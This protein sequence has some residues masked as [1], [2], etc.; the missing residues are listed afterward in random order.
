M[1]NPTISQIKVGNTTYDINDADA[2]KAVSKLNSWILDLQNSLS[3]VAASGG[4]TGVKGAG[5]PNY[6]QG[7]VNLT[8]R[9]I[10]PS[11]T[12]LYRTKMTDFGTQQF[13]S[14]ASAKNYTPSS[15]SGYTPVMIVG[16]EF[17][18]GGNLGM[19]V[20]AMRCYDGKVYLD[21]RNMNS[22]TLNLGLKVRC[23][24]VWSTFFYQE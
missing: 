21:V 6:R 14:G 3:E 2:R 11:T 23:L 15:I 20:E 22:S 12:Y 8:L 24:Y 13:A 10:I 5:E 4:V 1:A 7:N 16:V 9:D 18:G 17:S 19:I